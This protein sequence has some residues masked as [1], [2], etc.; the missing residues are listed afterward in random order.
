MAIPGTRFY[1]PLEF[2]EHGVHIWNNRGRGSGAGLRAGTHPDQVT[3]PTSGSGVSH[4]VKDVNN[5]NMSRAELETEK[6]AR[7][8]E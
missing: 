1:F 5:E 6:V 7:V 2:M 8:S 3:N 4:C